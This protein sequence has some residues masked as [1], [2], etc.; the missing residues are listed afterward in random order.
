MLCIGVE[1]CL[2]TGELHGEEDFEIQDDCVCGGKHGGPERARTWK[3]KPLC[4]G[5]AVC[6]IGPYEMSGDSKG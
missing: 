4:D 6:P 5:Y 1:S 3:C 2:R